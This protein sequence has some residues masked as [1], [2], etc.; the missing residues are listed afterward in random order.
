MD[1]KNAVRAL[2]PTTSPK[3]AMI[4]HRKD[5]RVKAMRSAH[6]HTSCKITVVAGTW[7]QGSGFRVQ[8]PEYRAQGAGCSLQFAVR[9]VQGSRQMRE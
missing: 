7:V 8:G 1:T 4:T 9:R 5:T 2:M 6:P 3:N